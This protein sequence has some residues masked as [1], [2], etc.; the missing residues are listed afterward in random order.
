M[1][2]GGEVALALHRCWFMVDG[3]EVALALHRC[4]FMVDGGEVALALH[5]CW[6][7]RYVAG[8]QGVLEISLSFVFG[9]PACSRYQTLGRGMSGQTSAWNAFCAL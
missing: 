9:N 6:S 1:V 4:W 3:G 5:R 7:G 8:V 2:D